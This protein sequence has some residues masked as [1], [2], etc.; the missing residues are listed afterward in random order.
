MK[1]FVFILFSYLWCGYYSVHMQRNYK[2]TSKESAFASQ[3]ELNDS[4][5]SAEVSLF[6]T[7]ET[8]EIEGY[9]N[10]FVT[11]DGDVYSRNF[12]GMGIA[13]KMKLTVA[14][15]GYLTVRLGRKSGLLLV[16][17][18]IAEAFIPNPEMKRT[19]NHKNMV[20]SDNSVGNLEWA[21][22]QEN[23][24]HSFNNGRKSAVGEKVHTAKLSAEEVLQIRKLYKPR[25][26][27]YKILA[28]KF[29]ISWWQ[30]K[31]ITDRN[32]WKHI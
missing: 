18:L 29:G 31:K 17:R 16:H 3:K 28:E 8:K 11:S 6:T 5:L 27:T 23:H 15:N 13:K 4:P 19:V 9:P 12:K 32:D 10:Y 24:I 22:Y 26:I 1:Y 25:V 7:M 14:F 2:S 21:T 30:V 20:K